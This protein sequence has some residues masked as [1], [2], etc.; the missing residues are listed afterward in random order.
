M[1]VFLVYIAR[2][3]QIIDGFV[4]VGR[5]GRRLHLCGYG[6]PIALSQSCSSCDHVLEYTQHGRVGV[7]RD[8]VN[9]RA[10]Q[11]DIL[12]AH[13]QR[14]TLCSSLSLQSMLPDEMSTRGDFIL[15]EALVVLAGLKVPPAVPFCTRVSE[16]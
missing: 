10:Y 14:C 6:H 11:N 12:G 9:G 3:S 15:T 1:S 13:A 2:V 8:V 16:G 5:T 7:Y 4:L